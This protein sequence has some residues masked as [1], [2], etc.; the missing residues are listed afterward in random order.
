MLFSKS[1]G[2]I[3]P[4]KNSKKENPAAIRIAGVPDAFISS[5]LLFVFLQKFK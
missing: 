4:Q 2:R 3:S 1:S 5:A